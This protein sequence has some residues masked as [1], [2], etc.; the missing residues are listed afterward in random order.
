[1]NQTLSRYVATLFSILGFSGMITNAETTYSPAVA[2]AKDQYEQT[3]DAAKAT[4]TKE[5]NDALAQAK[6]DNRVDEVTAIKRILEDLNKTND[7]AFRDSRPIPTTPHEMKAYL[8]GTSWKFADGKIVTLLPTGKVK[9]SW[10]V[11]EPNW[12]VSKR[13]LQFENKNFFFNNDFTTMEEAGKTEFKGKAIRI[14]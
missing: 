3:I 7:A 13:I 9:K 12:K 5:L 6:R 4:Y 8:D 14:E 11:L 2:K 1:M 10:G